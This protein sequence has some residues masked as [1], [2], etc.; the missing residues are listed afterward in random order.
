M[1]DKMDI[2]IDRNMHKMVKV[3]NKLKKLIASTSHC[4]LM[5]VVIVEVVLNIILLIYYVT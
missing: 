4:C 3:D 1:L 5:T 2:D